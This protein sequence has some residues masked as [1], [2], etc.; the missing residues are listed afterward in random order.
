MSSSLRSDGTVCVCVC[1]LGGG[2]GVGDI[3]GKVLGLWLGTCVLVSLI[4]IKLVHALRYRHQFFSLITWD[5]LLVFLHFAI[6][7]EKLGEGSIVVDELGIATNLRDLTV[8]HHNDLVTLWEEPYAMG[9]Q[10][11]YLEG[12]EWGVREGVGGEGGGEGVGRG[13]SGREGGL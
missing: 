13:G 1:A 12:R 10:D 5:S 2:G 7:P 11:T 9:H 8:S 3:R 6:G 4:K